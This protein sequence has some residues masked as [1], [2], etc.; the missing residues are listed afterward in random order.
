MVSVGRG[1]AGCKKSALVVIPNEVRNP[2][3][4]EGRLPHSC[5]SRVGFSF[6]PMD[7][8]HMLSF[9][10]KEKAGRLDPA[11]DFKNLVAG[12]CNHPNCL[13]LPFRLELIHPTPVPQSLFR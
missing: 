6:R 13:L 10:K 8:I 1:F 5:E 7:I 4:F 3:G 12:G 11:F 2:S 9:A